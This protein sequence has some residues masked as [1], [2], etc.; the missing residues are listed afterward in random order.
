MSPDDFERLLANDPYNQ[1]RIFVLRCVHDAI[2][3]LRHGPHRRQDV[4]SSLQEEVLGEI[5]LGISSAVMEH[6]SQF[7]RL[8]RNL[9][10]VVPV[11]LRTLRK[12]NDRESDEDVADDLIN[13][14][15]TA[16][17]QPDRW[18]PEVEEFS[19]GEQSEK[20]SRYS[21]RHR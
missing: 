16:L 6:D 9:E 17:Q 14:I 15:P 7:E 20:Q 4:I 8:C 5:S 18:A 11:S 3:F 2:Y 12:Y 10:L 21:H 13:C 19:D 1:R